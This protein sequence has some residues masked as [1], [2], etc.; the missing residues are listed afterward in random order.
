MKESKFFKVLRKYAFL[1]VSALI[2]AVGISLFL[3]PNSL[4]PGGVSGI[5]IILS[6]MTP[7]P[8]GTWALLINI[9]ILL[10]GVWKFGWR[11][12]IS[13]LYCIALSSGMINYLGHYP[14]LTQDPFLAAVAGGALM[15][16]GIGFIFKYG[17]TTGGSDIV[18]KVLRLR[19]PHL[20][21]GNLF[22]IL[23]AL[24]VA[25]S[26]VAFRDINKALYA[27]LAVSVTSVVMDFV[28]YG[29]DEAKL[30]YI[31]S[32]QSEKIAGRLLEELDIG[33][34]YVHGVGAYSGKEKKV[35]MCAV[36][37]QLAP[38]AEDIVREEEPMAFM[39][40]TSATEIYGEGYKSIFSER[41]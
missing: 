5:A 30:L 22:L 13:T 19:Y 18:V 34:T 23:D 1:A 40:V 6:K 35:I 29:K 38:K 27:A 21:T 2:Y 31:I 37:K 28:L 32:D 41:I 39:I 10:L 16:V 26:A 15:A 17:A 25:M 33:V 20:K 9:P 8:T 12:I 4:A 3:D 24:V 36:K 14:A 11:F 7:V